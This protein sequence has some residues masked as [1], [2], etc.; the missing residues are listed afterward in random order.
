MVKLEALN[1]RILRFIIGDYPSPYTTL[2][3]KVNSTSWCNKRVQNFF[4]LSYNNL[5]FAPFPAYMKNMF[6]LWSSSSSWQLHSFA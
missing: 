5:C 1:K 6:S 3:S 4:I 2:L